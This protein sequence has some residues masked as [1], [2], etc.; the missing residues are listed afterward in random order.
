MKMTVSSS[1]AVADPIS[2]I[3]P[4]TSTS[5]TN[6][7]ESDNKTPFYPIKEKYR[8]NNKDRKWPEMVK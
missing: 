6:T 7:T 3:P 8:N 1:V 5:E 2:P 4:F